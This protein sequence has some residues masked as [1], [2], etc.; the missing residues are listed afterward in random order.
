[1]G[2]AEVTCAAP[3]W[4]SQDAMYFKKHTI[5]INFLVVSNVLS[6]QE[7]NETALI[8]MHEKWAGHQL[9]VKVRPS[10]HLV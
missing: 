4:V 1:M 5:K 6:S 8:F 10:L 2:L 9:T 3:A 7:E